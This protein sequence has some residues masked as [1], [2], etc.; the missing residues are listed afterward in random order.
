[1]IYFEYKNLFNNPSPLLAVNNSR[2]AYP[3]LLISIG[4][5]MIFFILR[6]GSIMAICKSK[7]N[8]EF[9]AIATKS[10]AGWSWKLS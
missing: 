7:L 4:S 9:E 6:P 2:G 8:S 10:E 1:V 3:S 5:E